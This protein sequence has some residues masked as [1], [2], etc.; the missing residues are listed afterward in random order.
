LFFNNFTR[1]G[2]S[3]WGLIWG[4]CGGLLLALFSEEE[5]FYFQ[6]LIQQTT[7]HLG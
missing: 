1:R 6:F 2:I 4:P 3:D 5:H 7:M